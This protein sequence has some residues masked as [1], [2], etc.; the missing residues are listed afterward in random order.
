MTNILQPGPVV[1]FRLG[2]Y[3]PPPANYQPPPDWEVSCPGT[4]P[5]RGAAV[6]F[7]T[8][9]GVEPA[10]RVPYPSSEGTDVIHF[11]KSLLGGE[12]NVN[13]GQMFYVTYVGGVVLMFPPSIVTSASNTIR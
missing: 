7:S 5:V 13:T 2:T 3:C 12:A 1:G 11:D 10:Y 4:L 9:S 6:Q 8:Q